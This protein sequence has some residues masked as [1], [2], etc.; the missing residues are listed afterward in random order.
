MDIIKYILLVLDGKK[1]LIVA[2]LGMVVIWVSKEAW[3]DLPT[4]EL[5]MGIVG[6]IGGGA[7]YATKKLIQ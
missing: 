4:A 2:I 5:L 6:L 3:I 7:S 1:T